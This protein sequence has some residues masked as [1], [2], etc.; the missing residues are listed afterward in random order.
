MDSVNNTSI[1]KY[2]LYH[3]TRFFQV[4]LHLGS[5]TNSFLLVWF[6]FSFLFNVDFVGFS[7]FLNDEIFIYFKD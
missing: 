6:G 1:F 4:F 7:F 5:G 2:V 3:P